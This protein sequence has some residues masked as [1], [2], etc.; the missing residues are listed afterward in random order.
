MRYVLAVAEELH[1]GRAA[2]RLHIA[3]P[4]LSQ[5]IKALEEELGAAL[6]VR[7]RRKVELT[8]A[9]RLFVEEARATLAQAERA[10]SVIRAAAEGRRGRLAIGYVTSAAQSILPAA[11]RAYVRDYPETE[12]SL[13]E[14]KPSEQ[15]IALERREIELGLL[16]PP[17]TEPGLSVRVI[18]NE[19]LWVAIPR[20]HPLARR[21][22][23][24]LADLQSQPLILFPR[25]HGPG[26]YDVIHQACHNA[27]FTPA[28]VYE[29]NEMQSLLTHVA[30]GLGISIIPASASQLHRKDIRYRPLHRNPLSIALA[31]IWPESTPSIPR[32]RFLEYAA[33]VAA[34]FVSSL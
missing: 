12:L 11:I 29:P 2:R 17:V 32:D 13:R 1:F 31:A 30:A 25:R 22:R 5:Q 19:P 28:P 21:P 15:L 10:R 6:F 18:M 9:G 24:V 8:E 23:I 34:H 7:T 4:P 26:L 33:P 14:M 20:A 16:R 3:Q 27:G